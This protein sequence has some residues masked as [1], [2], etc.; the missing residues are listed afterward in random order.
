[1]ELIED[2]TDYK[3]ELQKSMPSKNHSKLQA[4]L[5]YCLLRAYENIFDIHSEL[6]LELPTGKVNPD[7]AIFLAQ[8]SDWIDDEIVVKQAPLCVI[9]ILSPTQGIQDLV[10]KM[11]I[12]FGAGVKSYWIVQ[13]VFQIIHVFYGKEEYNS[14]LK[15]SVIDKNLNISIAISD[16]FK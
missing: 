1:M 8:K 10:D 15:D 16:I 4:R 9:E 14:F 7:I 6:S 3:I 13:P 12:Y 5:S 2:V 11:D